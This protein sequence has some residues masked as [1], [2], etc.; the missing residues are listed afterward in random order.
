MFTFFNVH[1][2]V[3]QGGLLSPLLFAVYMDELI[4]KLQNSGYGCKMKGV[5]YGCFAYADD[6]MLVSHS[7][8]AMQRMLDI[9][10]SFAVEL[11]IQFNATKSVAMR[12][13]KRHDVKC[14]ELELSGKALVYVR[15]LKYLGVHIIASNNFRCKYDHVKH[16][17]YKIFNAIYSKSKAADSELVTVELFRS[18]CLPLMLYAVEA[19]FPC[20]QDIRAFDNCV[21]LAMIKIFSVST[22]ANIS[23]IREYL[24]LEDMGKIIERRRLKFIDSL[25]VFPV[26]KELVNCNHDDF[27]C[28]AA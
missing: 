8:T 2:G 3:R 24:G 28:L 16:K 20:K 17:F 25:L 27:M 18:Y 4:I 15:S 7:I 13:G 26:F 1:A 23:A 19:T 6:I 11:D 12:I 9:C 5:F 10:S 14:A 21:N 22:S